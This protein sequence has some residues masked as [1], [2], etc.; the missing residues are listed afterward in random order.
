MAVYRPKYRDPKTGKLK[1]SAQW[2]YEFIY[3]GDRIR[4]SAK[5]TRKT[6]AK[7][8]EDD[9]RRQLEQSGAT[10]MPSG[11]A[12]DTR[13]KRTRR[14][15][16]ALDAYRTLYAAKGDHRKK[17][18][19]IVNERSAVVER[20]LGSKSAVDLTEECLIDYIGKR[21]ADSVSGRTINMELAVLSRAMGMKW[22]GLRLEERRDVGRALSPE[23]EQGIVDAA[24][25]NVSR[26]IHPVV[27]IAL[28]TGMRRDEIR[29]LRWNQ[30]NFEEKEI[31][32]GRAKSEKGTGRMIPFGEKLAAVLS[33]YVSWYVSKLGPI[34]ED[35]YVFP[36]SN[37]RMPVDPTRPV[38]SI[39][40]AWESVRETAGVSCRFH[41]LRHTL[42][43]KMA[44]AGVPESTMLAIMG[45]MS[46][47]MLEKYSHIR[48]QAKR[49]AIQSIE[50]GSAAAF[51]LGVP[52]VSP[53]VDTGEGSK[54][55]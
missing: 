6:V 8:A 46:K 42:C 33:M 18:I 20:Y 49:D 9:R 16:A 10:G 43:T 34:Q 39:K 54:P 15:Q 55:S 21:K 44:E 50:A 3:D 30:I 4:E 38:T 19:Q 23:E 7:Q 41:D 36:F 2:W 11:T 24:A 28:V 32:V 45:H 22:P 35:W 51:S 31:T 14:V 25:R 27:R 52:K 17:G 12:K 5:T 26:M 1:Q 40:T 48:K 37:R 47:A 13:S 53:K 29:L